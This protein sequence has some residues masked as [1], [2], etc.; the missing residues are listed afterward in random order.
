MIYVIS[1]T[2]YVKVGYTSNLEKRLKQYD[3]HNPDYTIYKTIKKGTAQHELELHN[4]LKEYKYQGE[5][6]HL[7]E[8][9]L[10][11]IDN[12]KLT[13]I[14]PRKPGKDVAVE[15]Y[16]ELDHVHTLYMLKAIKAKLAAKLNTDLKSINYAISKLKKQG[17]L[18]VLS[19]GVYRVVRK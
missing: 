4:L 19:R 17:L 7:N 9:V 18:E 2:K 8:E 16:A 13:A 15:L 11:I 10:Q 14:I 6:F 5:W 12:Y 1:T 3:T